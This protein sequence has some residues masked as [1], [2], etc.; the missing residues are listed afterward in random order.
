MASV[1]TTSMAVRDGS[2]T[3][4]DAG[5]VSV[6]A[7]MKQYPL[8]DRRYRRVTLPDGLRVLRVADDAA[9]TAAACRAI[10][11]GHCSNPPELPRLAHLY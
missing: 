10:I 8:D 2:V 5:T 11:I 6:P 1:G 7:V 9:E 3:P 4:V